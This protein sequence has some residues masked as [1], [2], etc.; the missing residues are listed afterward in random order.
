MANAYRSSIFHDLRHPVLKWGYIF[1]IPGVA[2]YLLFTLYPIG[3][4]LYQSFH[5]I[6]GAA[7]PWKF[8][9]LSNYQTIFKDKIF[10]DS[11]RITIV[12]VLMTVPVGTFIS[13]IVAIALQNI[14]R[15]K[16]FFRAFFFIPSV[17][18]IVA[19]GI[20][21]GWLYEPYNGLL[22]LIFE[23]VGLPKLNWLRDENLALACIAAM[24]IWRTMGYNMVI[25]LAGLL[26]IPP[27]YYE[28][29]DIDGVGMLRKHLSIT[30]P[31]VSPALWFVIIYNTIKNMQVFTEVFVM[32][33]GGPGHATTTIG[34]RI[35][36]NA[37][38]FISFGRA[39]ANAV[40]L[41]LIIL[42]I[43]LIQLR[44]FNQGTKIEY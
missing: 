19:V 13:L 9:G 38:V 36:Q 6:T 8:V 1:A 31:L 16:G 5:L 35:Y 3:S 41:L 14:G 33:G 23:T 34:F 18:G 21:W 20:I 40:V 29:A 10:W 2:A 43:T 30:L 7:N 4:T 11:L 17:A 27:Q 25:L 15:G 24:T 28:V 37:F 22:N 12:Y 42:V 44:F 26:S 32:T 39:A